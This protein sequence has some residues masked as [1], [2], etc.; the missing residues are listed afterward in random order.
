MSELLAFGVVQPWDCDVMGHFTVRRYAAVFDDASY[1]LLW[2][3]TGEPP[4]APDGGLGW[5]DVKQVYEY[6]A[7][8][9]AGDL[10]EITGRPVRL[11]TSSVTVEY[12][13][14]R[15]GSGDLVASMT[16]SLVRF[17]LAARRASPIEGEMRA[18]I[19]AMLDHS[20]A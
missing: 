13:M 4:V 15:R 20:A 19:E 14:Q 11:G 17:D 1:Q 3:M 9:R 5:A 7:E 10:Y 18:R 6:H 16:S 2:A 8:M 12:R